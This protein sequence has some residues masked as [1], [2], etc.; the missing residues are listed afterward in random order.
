MRF[1]LLSFVILAF[2]FYQLSGG[3]DF[4]PNAVREARMAK[5]QLKEPSP[6]VAAP[7]SIVDQPPVVVAVPQL[8]TKP[9]PP[10]VSLNLTSLRTEENGTPVH[11]TVVAQ[12]SAPIDTSATEAAVTAALEEAIAEVPQ[13][14]PIITTSADTPAIIPSLINPT[15]GL[16]E[17]VSLQTQASG[18]ADLR[19]VSG[20]RVNVRG[21]PGTDFNVVGRLTQGDEIVVLEDNG[22]GWVRFETPD[23]L[24]QGWMAD[25]LL[26]SG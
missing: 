24:T 10:P 21:G 17:T 25:F 26:T 11:K 4:D 1:I 23:G 12:P 20:T 8:E 22:A 6:V 18:F 3:S 15:D 2:A 9:A 19:T 13:N 5:L 7:T 16:T 14:A